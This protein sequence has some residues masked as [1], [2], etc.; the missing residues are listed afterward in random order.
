MA[1]RL[2]RLNLRVP[3]M[4][5]ALLVGALS[6]SGCVTREASSTAPGPNPDRA[7]AFDSIDG[8]P[9]GVFNRLVAN[10]DSEAHARGLPVVT[11]Q[12]PAAFRVRG[13][14]AARMS[15]KTSTIAWVWDVYDPAQQRRLRIAGVEKTNGRSRDPWAGADD[16][17][18]R[19]IAHE[20]VRAFA[21]LLAL[22][23]NTPPGAPGAVPRR[24]A[25][26]A[27][28]A[29]PADDGSEPPAMLAFAQSEDTR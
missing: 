13:Y 1:L 26:P 9:A 19:K 3:G 11:R 2:S 5:L 29:L 4:A 27:V 23:E 16:K 12:A 25:G 20:G 22:P 28:A 8:P 10:L 7:V 24:P 14:L 6:L 17:L 15:G 18:L 21:G